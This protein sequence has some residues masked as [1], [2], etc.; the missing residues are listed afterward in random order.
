LENGGQ[1]VYLEDDDEVELTGWCQGDGYRVGFG[2]CSGSILP[3]VP[4]PS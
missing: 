1:R 2:T 3:A 4:Y